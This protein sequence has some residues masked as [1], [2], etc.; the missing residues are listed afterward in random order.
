MADGST[1]LERRIAKALEPIGSTLLLLVAQDQR[2][3]A[4]ALYSDPE[5][6]ACIRR[7]YSPIL[8]HSSRP[9]LP[10]AQAELR[11]GV[12]KFID[13]VQG[14][15]PHYGKRMVT[16]LRRDHGKSFS[17]LYKNSV[18]LLML[19][20]IPSPDEEISI[21]LPDQRSSPIYTRV[22]FDRVI[23]DSGNPLHPLLRKEAIAETRKYLYNELSQIDKALQGSN[24]DRKYVEAF[25][26]LA[27]LISFKDDAGAIT[28]GL[29]VKLVSQLTRKIEDELSEIFNV[30]IAST[31]T[32]SA[33]FA[34]QYKDWMEFVHNAE[35]YPSRSV[36]E[37]SIEGCLAEVTDLLQRNS[38]TVDERIPNSIKVLLVML[39]GTAEQ[40]T[41][42]IYASV[43][44]VENF[45]I[46]TVKYSYEQAKRFMQDV[47]GMARPVLIAIGSAAIIGLALDV[48][49][50]FMPVI[51][52]ASELNWIVENLPNIE[53]IGRILKRY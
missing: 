9:L 31:L 21:V 20:D 12:L 5:F 16:E 48:I 1:E 49:M 35:N 6:N 13:Y 26:R 38:N 50:Q 8:D 37:D 52:I 18:A 44:S 7:Y 40:R 19:L 2:V 33:Y 46:A 23:L 39:K 30:Q 22:E 43:R 47:G 27:D 41:H 42:A 24:V 14:R 36:I 53:K 51:R 3:G 25:S 10:I 34:S 28:F 45:C 17:Q 29:H 32:H 4:K 11:D 15:F